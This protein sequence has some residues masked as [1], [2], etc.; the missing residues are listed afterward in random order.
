[1]PQPSG[2]PT[3]HIAGPPDGPRFGRSRFWLSA[4]AGTNIRC[5]RRSLFYHR[6]PIPNTHNMTSST[7]RD[8]KWLDEE[9][10]QLRPLP[11]QQLARPQHD[12][13]AL[14]LRG[15]DR[16]EAYRRAPRRFTDRLRIGSIGLATLDI[17][18]DL[19]RGH[20]PH[21]VPHRPHT[22][23]WTVWITTTGADGH[24]SARLVDSVK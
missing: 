23:F 17:G 6:A 19:L 4:Q 20:Q 15:L 2:A 1:M 8:I 12:D 21:A 16:H 13:R 7:G 11:H 9:R 18:L 24:R 3:A 10:P 5:N 22:R 14:S